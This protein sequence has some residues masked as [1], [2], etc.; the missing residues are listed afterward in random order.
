MMWPA[1]AGFEAAIVLAVVA[2]LFIAFALELF[3]PEVVA[4]S[5]VA[6][7]LA[8]GI[9][10]EKGL[11]L[12]A[13]NSAPATI[14]AMFILS[15][16]LVRTG[17]LDLVTER[18][19]RIAGLGPV[20]ALAALLAIVA[21]GSAFMNN[22][23]LVVVMIPVTV[24]LSRQLGISASALLMPLSY[25]AILGG[26]CTLIGTSTNLVVSGV[27]GELGLAPF[28]IFEITPLGILVAVAGGLYM[29]TIGRRL[30]PDRHSLADVAIRQRTQYL[31]ELVVTHNSRLIGQPATEVPLFTGEGR[32]LVDVIRGNASLRR[33]LR[34]VRL[35]AGDIVVIKSPVQEILDLRADAGVSLPEIEEDLE[36]VA[37]RSSVLTEAL[38]TPGSRLIGTTLGQL[39]LR[40][41]YGLYPLALHRHGESTGRLETTPLQVGDTLLLEGA[42]ED[43]H[44]FARD[45]DIVNVA[46]PSERAFRRSKAALAALIFAGV[47]IA[48]VLELMP[49]VALAWIGVAIV[50]LTRCVDADE[51]FRA[52]DGRLIVLLL[53]MLAIGRALDAS[54][55]VAM[56]VEGLVPFIRDWPI[57]AI[58]AV[59]YF[60]SSALTEAVTNNAVAV[61]MAP[62]MVALAASLGADPRPFLVA[63]MFAA[64]ASFA[65]P[66]GYQT[67]TLVYSAGGYRFMDFVRVGVPLNI[68]CGI[69]T[70]LAIPLFWPLR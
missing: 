61:V 15:A 16:A 23:P 54:G 7:L 17:A 47:V 51:A 9:L 46:E 50:L 8:L 14:I 13:S 63:V 21:A 70:V 19:S 35:A 12:A 25:A 62:V 3:P 10:D 52:V 2:G 30:L 11:L 40:R 49:I 53:A 34:D 33:N 24:A 69:V 38:L 31:L 45:M 4:L 20:P 55:A 44:R 18:L 59:I 1:L 26:T 36:P 42:R 6:V 58:L 64:S 66:I 60:L 56:I 22:T 5:G 41:H 29:L 57:L 68:I 67:N 39:R 27:A 37:A 28:S 43:V 65:T 32:H 48:A